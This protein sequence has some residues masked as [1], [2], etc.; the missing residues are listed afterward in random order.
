MSKGTTPI[1][2][3]PDI[4]LKSSFMELLTFAKTASYVLE[5]FRT[6]FPLLFISSKLLIII[7]TFV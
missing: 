7:F 5:G 4:V 3:A 2:M 6:K 1:G